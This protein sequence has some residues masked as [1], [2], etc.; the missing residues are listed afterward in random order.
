MPDLPPEFPMHNTIDRFL[1]ARIAGIAEDR[2]ATPADGVDYYRDVQPILEAKCY[3]CHQGGSAKGKLGLD[4][5]AAALKGGKSDGPAIVPGKPAES[6]LFI[7]ATADPDEIMPPE[8]KGE[9]LNRAELATLER[10]IAEGAH[11]PDLRFSTLKMTPLADDL[12]FL[13]RVTLDT[14]GLVPSEKEIRDFSADNSPDRRAKMIDRLLADPRW[15]D[16]WMGYWQDVLAENPNLLNPTLNNTGPFRW[17]IYESLLD[18]KPMDLFVTELIRMEGSRL[19]GGP[20]GFGMASQNDVPMAQKAMIVSSAFLGVEMK[21]A[22]CHDSP[23]NLTKQQDLFELAAMM[24]RKP[25]KLP[26]TSSV[27]LDRIHQ[28]G[29]EP[30]IKSRSSRAA[31]WSPSGRWAR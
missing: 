10:W 4:T 19:F 3:S 14:V 7:R 24:G 1:A 6:A 8:G 25:I 2:S 26:E 16:R 15:A 27:P 17:W 12:T 29:R 13:R 30:L 5:L 28:S 9:P 20:A 11:W 18:D 21:C 22:R 23:A 31:P